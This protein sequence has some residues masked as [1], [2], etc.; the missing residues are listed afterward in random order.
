MKVYWL[1]KF[2][3]VQQVRRANNLATFMCWLS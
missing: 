1:Q 2:S 3:K